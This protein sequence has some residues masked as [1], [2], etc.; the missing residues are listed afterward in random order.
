MVC[1]VLI[2]N[3]EHN[4]PIRDKLI[5]KKSE[6]LFCTKKKDSLILYYCLHLPYYFLSSWYIF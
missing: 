2:A 3:M 6:L 5:D 1:I 4:L